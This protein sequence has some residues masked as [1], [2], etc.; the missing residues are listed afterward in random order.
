MCKLSICIKDNARVSFVNATE[1]EDVSRFFQRVLEA[2]VHVRDWLR[3]A[4][5]P[6]WL[7]G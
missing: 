6:S 1:E 5:V 4:R 3:V 2:D 7:A